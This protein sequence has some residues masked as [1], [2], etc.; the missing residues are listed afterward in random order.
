MDKLG[1][2]FITLSGCKPASL[3]YDMNEP[4]TFLNKCTPH[5]DVVQVDKN[6]KMKAY[7]AYI[8]NKS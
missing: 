2:F 6:D 3:I 4:L 5:L 1:I 8:L 7:H